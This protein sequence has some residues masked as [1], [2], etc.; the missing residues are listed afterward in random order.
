[1]TSRERARAF[2]NTVTMCPQEAGLTLGDVEDMLTAALDAHAT[3][4]VRCERWAAGLPVRDRDAKLF[5]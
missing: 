4:A 5:A 3:A 2:L 1:M